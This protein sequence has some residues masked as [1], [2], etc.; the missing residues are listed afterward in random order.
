MVHV[1]TIVLFQV[2]S[3]DNAGWHVVGE[4]VRAGFAIGTLVCGGTFAE[5]SDEGS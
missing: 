5:K 1:A 2:R 4:S 3:S